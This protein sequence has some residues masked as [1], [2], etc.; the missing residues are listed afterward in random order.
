M[1]RKDV[2]TFE[3]T[4][5]ELVGPLLRRYCNDGRAWIVSSCF[6]RVQAI[7]YDRESDF[8]VNAPSDCYPFGG[9]WRAGAWHP[10]SER[11]V[12]RYNN[13]AIGNE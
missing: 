7:A 2:V 10:F 8:P 11:I 6:G 3:V 4:G 1:S 13:S 5:R 9:F 12:R